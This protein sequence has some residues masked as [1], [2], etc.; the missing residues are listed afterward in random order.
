MVTIIINPKYISVI[1][2]IIIQMFILVGDIYAVNDFSVVEKALDSQQVQ[3]ISSPNLLTSIVKLVFVL[4]LIVI[5]AWSIIRLFGRKVSSRLQGTWIH[6]VDEVI[7][8]HNRGIALCEVGKKVYAIGVTDNS[9]TLLFEVE[10]SQ[11]LE[12]ISHSNNTVADNDDLLPKYDWKKT[13]TNIIKP[14]KS[15]PKVSNSF[16]TLIEEQAKRLEDIYNRGNSYS[17]VNLKKKDKHE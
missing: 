12:E 2:L 15:S 11:L 1:I 7:L 5:A 10:N 4:T 6:V 9:I 16:H 14:L 3:E 13:L 8:G 17:E